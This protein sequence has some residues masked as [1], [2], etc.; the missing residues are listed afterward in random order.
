MLLSEYKSKEILRQY[1]VEIPAARLAHTAVEAEAACD[2]LGARKYVVKAQIKAGGRGLAGGVKFAATPSS[3]RDEAERLLGR[4]LVTAQTLSEG[5]VVEA[6]SVEA[7]LDLKRQLFLAIALDPDTGF[8]LLLA[9]SEGGVTFEERVRMDADALRTFLLADGIT[10][11]SPALADFLSG[12]GAT[13]AAPASTVMAMRQAFIDTDMTLLEVNPFAETAD[14]RWLAIDAKIIID[15]NAMFRHP[16]FESFLADQRLSPTE[17]EAQRANINF[18]PL[19]G[20][21]GVV[22]NGAGLGLAT[23]D[24]IVDARGKPA[25]FMDIRTTATS[26]DIAR[27][28]EILLKDPKVRA[29]LLNVHGGGMTV[30]DTVAEG[31]AFAYARSARKVPVAVCLGGQNAEWGLRILQDRKVPVEVF[32]DMKSAAQGAVA[33]AGGAR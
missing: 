1:G 25:N 17:S 27:G 2:G 7:A 3:V 20:N 8:P 4:R 28:V 23:N 24:M 10:A 11:E 19:D 14:G 5:E 30:C 32:A 16:E 15:D 6:V 12:I 21:I 29:I 26:F 33:M 13:G 9:S 22:V 18:V 31:V